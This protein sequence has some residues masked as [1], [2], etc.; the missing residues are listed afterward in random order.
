MYSSLG[1]LT[2]TAFPSVHPEEFSS[3]S[4]EQPQTFHWGEDYY[5]VFITNITL[6]TVQA[7]FGFHQE[8]RALC[9]K[10]QCIHMH[11]CTRM[12][13]TH[14]R[15]QQTETMV[16]MSSTGIPSAGMCNALEVTVCR[17]WLAVAME[18]GSWAR[19]TLLND[20]CQQLFYSSGSCTQA[21]HSHPT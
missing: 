12:L 2:H 18:T 4:Y 8:Q 6:V 14:P 9:A 11:A 20:V 17:Q 10:L 3:C 15:A 13:R 7:C 19:E 5:I 21:I 16:T 1:R